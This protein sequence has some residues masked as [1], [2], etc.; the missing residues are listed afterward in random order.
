MVALLV[1]EFGALCIA[2]V[3][4]GKKGLGVLRQNSQL[5]TNPAENTAAAP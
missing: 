4:N 2:T 5:F 1:L 3:V